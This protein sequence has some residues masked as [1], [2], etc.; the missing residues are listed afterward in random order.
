MTRAEYNTAVDLYADN[1]F[2]LYWRMFRMLTNP[3]TLSKIRFKGVEQ[4]WRLPRKKPNRICFQRVQD[5]DWPDSKRKEA[6]QNGRV[7]PAR[8][9]SGH[10]QICRRI[11]C[12][13]RSTWSKGGCAI[14]RYE[15]YNYSE[16]GEITGWQSPRW[17]YISI[18]RKFLQK[19]IGNMEVL[20]W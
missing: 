20:I 1:L 3:R 16:I 13:T 4:P 14:A 17:R 10:S 11:T 19:Y 9:C 15:G 6:G 5:D 18:N 7:G 8:A 12:C 2:D